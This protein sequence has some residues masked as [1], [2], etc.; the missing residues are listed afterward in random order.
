MWMGTRDIFVSAGMTVLFI[1]VMDFL[2]NE[3]SI[4][5]C[6]PETFTTEHL[7]KLDETN[8][9]ISQDDIKNMEAILEKAKHITT[10]MDK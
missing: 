5:C 7:T 2:L 6:L 8:A 10:L 9:K 4:F 3:N 1:I